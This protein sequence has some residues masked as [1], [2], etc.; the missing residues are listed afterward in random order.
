MCNARPD[1]KEVLP[2]YERKQ[3]E[4][5]LRNEQEYYFDEVEEEWAS[6]SRYTLEDANWIA[7]SS[8]RYRLI[9]FSNFLTS[10]KMIQPASPATVQ[11]TVRPNLDDILQDAVPG[12][13]LMVLGGKGKRYDSIYT[14][15]DRIA[16]GAAF[17]PKVVD[18]TVSHADSEVAE[19]VYAT[20]KQF[21]QF[22]EPHIA[23]H[24]SEDTCEQNDVREHFGTSPDRA[25]SSALRVWRKYRFTKKPQ[26]TADPD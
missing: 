21:F 1:F 14:D 26:T 23:H 15:V 17:Q 20:G 2:S 19:Q 22:L 7:Q 9:T 13:V 3:L 16:R 8:Y 18:K 4:Q 25:H 24:A 11:Q 12:S 10:P 6:E 5:S